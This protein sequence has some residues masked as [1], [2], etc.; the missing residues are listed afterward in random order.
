M[1][2][3]HPRRS[4]IVLEKKLGGWTYRSR[5]RRQDLQS[6]Y[7]FPLQECSVGYQGVTAR[8]GGWDKEVSLGR[9][10]ER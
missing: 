5:R 6:A 9:D 7:L 8:V 10:I 3:G 1:K 4:A 2:R